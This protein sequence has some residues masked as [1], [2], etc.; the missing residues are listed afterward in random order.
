MAYGGAEVAR[1]LLATGRPRPDTFWL[2]NRIQAYRT[3]DADNDF[4]SSLDINND[5]DDHAE[6]EFLLPWAPFPPDN[7]CL[8]QYQSRAIEQ[9]SATVEGA[10][11]L[12]YNLPNEILLRIFAYIVPT[13]AAYHIF[14][15]RYHDR[16]PFPSPDG[17][18]RD[19]CCAACR[20][21]TRNA[22]LF[23]E[24]GDS[25]GTMIHRV[26]RL[27]C[28]ADSR[29]ARHFAA[30]ASTC[31]R[32]AVLY[33]K[34]FYGGNQF[35]L[36]IAA[37]GLKPRIMVEAPAMEPSD[38]DPDEVLA[39]ARE[40]RSLPWPTSWPKSQAAL[41]NTH[42]NGLWPLTEGSLPFVRHLT[43]LATLSERPSFEEVQHFERRL[44][45]IVRSL[46]VDCSLLSLTVDITVDAQFR[47]APTMR[48][49]SYSS[50]TRFRPQWQ[51]MTTK[52]KFD[53]NRSRDVLLW[54]QG[55]RR[56]GERETYAELWE[57]LRPLHGIE[58]V[59]LA[60]HISDDRAIRLVGS[61]QGKTE[62]A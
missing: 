62:E 24:D 61:M 46:Q 10:R 12:I 19:R 40:G 26:S 57:C 20:D 21:N 33:R 52:L 53:A 5:I 47:S 38:Y 14:P 25:L 42:P 41:W 54:L 49:C 8:S 29:P 28:D 45:A 30:L 39:A 13:R 31:H 58:N 34:L 7:S 11:P 23:A 27:P 48:I 15:A 43:V 36:E 60:G 44:H 18:A 51:L 50:D 1:R 2:H 6:R 37:D 56:L 3:Q 17:H 16:P 35:V 32:F 55:P 22:G 59:V 4:D 9:Q